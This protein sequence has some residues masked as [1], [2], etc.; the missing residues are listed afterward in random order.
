[1]MQRR[2]ASALLNNAVHW[3]GALAQQT[4]H[5]PSSLSSAPSEL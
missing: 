1:M 2:R 3:P 5:L 4:T